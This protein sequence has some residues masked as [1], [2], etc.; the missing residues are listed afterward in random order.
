SRLRALGST[1]SPLAA[2]SYEW[3]W[4]EFGSELWWCVISGG[5]DFA[6][7]FIG[8]NRMLP[9]TPGEMQ[10]RCRGAAV[11]AWD[12]N[13]KALVDEVGELFG[14]R[15]MRSLP[16]RLWGDDDG[17]R[18]RDSYFEMYPG[19]WRHGDWIRITPSGGAVISGRCD[20]TINRYG[21]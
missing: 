19:I 8:G 13:G 12:E 6:G 4:R 1:G 2:E 11:E 3:G 7:A 17:S 18:Y 20:A 15:A 9:T 10:C 5:T 14:G 21:I 16:L